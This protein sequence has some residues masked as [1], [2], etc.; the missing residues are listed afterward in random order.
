MRVALKVNK[1]LNFRLSLLAEYLAPT[2]AMFIFEFCM[3]ADLL[4]AD[5]FRTFL[6]VI[7]VREV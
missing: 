6:G 7:I 3:S 1:P 2:I 5:N 4:W